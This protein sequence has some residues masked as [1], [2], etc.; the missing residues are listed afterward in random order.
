MG[1]F[2]D[3]IPADKLPTKGGANAAPKADPRIGTARNLRA[4]L[5]RVQALYKQDFKGS[6][7]PQSLLEMNPYSEKSQRFN[8]AAAGLAPLATALTRVPGTGTVSDKDQSVSDR[9]YMPDNAS[10]DAANEERM[11]QLR[12]I[13]DSIDP[14]SPRAP[15]AVRPAMPGA[16]PRPMAPKFAPK[17]VRF[18]DLP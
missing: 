1:A 8:A 10:F 11:A 2:D 18:E 12:R 6:G 13:V 9:A 7:F 17:R 3:L 15:T 5:D 14:P 16:A 4:Q